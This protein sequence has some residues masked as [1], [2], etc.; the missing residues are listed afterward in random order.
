MIESGL[1]SKGR[2]IVIY[3]VQNN[4]YDAAVNAYRTH[5][6][7]DDPTLSGFQSVTHKACLD[8]LRAIGEE[9]TAS[10]LYGPYLDF[11]RVEKAIFG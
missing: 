11:S 5:L 6:I 4:N 2:F 3:P 10:A 1:Y 8:S 9:E 7:S